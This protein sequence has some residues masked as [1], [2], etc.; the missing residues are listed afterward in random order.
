MTSTA[1]R[2]RRVLGVDPGTR[3]AGWGVVDWQG[4]SARMVA[5]G[6]IRMAG[7]EMPDR[8][9]E[10]RRG[11]AEVVEAH[12]PTTLAVERPFVGKNARSALSVGMAMGVAMI[13]GADHGLDVHEYTPAVVKK[14]VVGNGGAA[15]EQVASMVCLI[16][17]L[18]EAPRPADATDAL[19]VALTHTHRAR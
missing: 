5:C 12:R 4:S 11:L 3:V 13:V 1:T 9:A 19:A 18:A 6:A 8:L 10:L 7:K 2:T 14:A 17:G 15:K 16:L